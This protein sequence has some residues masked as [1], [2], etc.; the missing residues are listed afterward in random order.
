[1]NVTPSEAVA[2]RNAFFGWPEDQSAQFIINQVSCRGSEARFIHCATTPFH[3][4]D[5]CGCLGAGVICS[6]E[7]E[8]KTWLSHTSM[9]AHA[10]QLYICIPTHAHTLVAGEANC[11]HGDVRLVDGRTTYEG[12]VEV[13]AHGRWGTVCDDWWDDRDTTVVCNQLN[14]TNGETGRVVIIV[15]CRGKQRP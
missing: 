11:T 14:Y 5:T 2:V 9:H 12:R 6:S 8:T 15:R 4:S 3:L 1:M 13:C 7:P 10:N